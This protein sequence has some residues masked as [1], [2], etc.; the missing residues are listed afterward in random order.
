MPLFAG[1]PASSAGT[2][3]QGRPCL[4]QDV[5]AMC[6]VHDDIVGC[7]CRATCWSAWAMC[8]PRWALHARP[9]SARI[10]ISSPPSVTAPCRW[11]RCPRPRRRASHAQVRLRCHFQPACIARMEQCSVSAHH[12]KQM[13]HMKPQQ[14]ACASSSCKIKKCM[15]CS[16]MCRCTAP[17]CRICLGCEPERWQAIT[18]AAGQHEL[19]VGVSTYAAASTRSQHCCVHPARWH[20]C[21]GSLSGAPGQEGGSSSSALGRLFAAGT[22]ENRAH[23]RRSQEA[24]GEG[25]PELARAQ[26]G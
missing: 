9:L 22:A 11:T 20:A 7:K 12:C 21:A 1:V 5:L 19:D 3:G 25:H 13:D 18:S 4:L 15:S 17:S 14:G 26:V 23:V 6:G 24:R 10:R 2:P 8:R 16:T